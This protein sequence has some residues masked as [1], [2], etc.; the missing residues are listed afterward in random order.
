MNDIDPATFSG[1]HAYF[2]VAFCAGDT[3]VAGHVLH[4]KNILLPDPKTDG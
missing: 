3:V 4:F 1:L 2:F